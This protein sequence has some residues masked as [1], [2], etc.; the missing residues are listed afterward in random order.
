MNTSERARK[1]S[2][3]RSNR[4]KTVA[5]F[6]PLLLRAAA[7]DGVRAIKP[8]SALTG[9]ANAALDV[10]EMLQLARSVAVPAEMGFA[11]LFST[12]PWAG[13]WILNRCHLILRSWELRRFRAP[14]RGLER[15]QREDQQR[16]AAL[17]GNT[18]KWATN[19]PVRKSSEPLPVLDI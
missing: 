5:L 2:E 7:F 14:L 11:S 1:P 15:P 9:K 13:Q 8:A 17:S 6:L 19:R 18:A 10:P 16:S 3:R 12:R 4:N